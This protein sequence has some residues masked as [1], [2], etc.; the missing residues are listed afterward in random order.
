VAAPS[1]E[2]GAYRVVSDTLVYLIFNNPH[3]KDNKN[4]KLF[5]ISNIDLVKV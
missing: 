5:K 4:I 2:R 3:N 1:S